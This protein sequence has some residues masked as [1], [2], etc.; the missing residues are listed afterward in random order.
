MTTVG[1]TTKFVLDTAG[2]LMEAATAKGA[3]A[4]NVSSE[5]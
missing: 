1:G 3:V 4:S 2:L 5:K